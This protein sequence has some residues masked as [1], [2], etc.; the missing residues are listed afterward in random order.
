MIIQCKFVRKSGV[1]GTLFRVSYIA[2][3]EYQL[4]GFRVTVE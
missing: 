4:H 3:Q 2:T 1:S